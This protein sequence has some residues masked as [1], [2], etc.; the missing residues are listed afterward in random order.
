MSRPYMENI[1]KADTG[2]IASLGVATGISGVLTAT[3]ATGTFLA[4][5][6]VGAKVATMFVAIGLGVLLSPLV[7]GVLAGVTALL[8]VTTIA[9]VLI[10]KHL[11]KIAEQKKQEKT[12]ILIEKIP[13][14]SLGKL[15]LE[16]IN[17][18][19][20]ALRK[21]LAKE[22]ERLI[23]LQQ[24]QKNQLDHLDD[25]TAGLQESKIEFKEQEENQDIDFDIYISKEAKE[26]LR[27]KGKNPDIF[28]NEFKALLKQYTREDFS[29]ELEKY[30]QGL[31]G[32]YFY[33]DH[34]G[35]SKNKNFCYKLVE[36]GY[37]FITSSELG[38][39]FEKKPVSRLISKNEFST[40]AKKG[41]DNM[42]AMESTQ[43]I[44][45]QLEV[46][47]DSQ[48]KD[49]APDDTPSGQSEFTT[50]VKLNKKPQEQ[51]KNRQDKPQQTSK[52]EVFHPLL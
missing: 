6:V 40:L 9:V 47:P 12:Q 7:C 36:L 3:A 45:K 39:R 41:Q 49:G 38:E 13:G 50:L 29:K 48:K 14:S 10:F 25:I 51:K 28:L 2:I 8:L 20:Q 35:L 37:I 23:E 15:E 5:T 4:T 52:Q 33:F 19:I 46:N 24:E 44:V 27:E 18:K 1:K 34:T 31:N 43:A 16:S 22:R 11:A 17:D 32:H 26:F 21:K 30:Y 42:T